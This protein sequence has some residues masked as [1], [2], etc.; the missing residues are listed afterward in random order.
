MSIRGF[1]VGSGVE[2][3]DY[4]YLDNLPDSE[5]YTAAEKAKL[6]ALPTKSEL[7]SELAGKADADDLAAVEQAVES[8]GSAITSAQI[9]A[10]FGGT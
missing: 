3:Y 1:N 2:K 4:N 5:E 10:L 8:M 6:G 7:D 9:H